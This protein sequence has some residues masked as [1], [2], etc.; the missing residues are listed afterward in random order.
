[1]KRIIKSFGIDIFVIEDYSILHIMNIET[2][3][4]I[5]C[6]T[7]EE[8][9]YILCH[10]Y[11]NC[12]NLNKHITDIVTNK[13]VGTCSNYGKYLDILKIDILDHPIISNSDFSGNIVLRVKIHV[14][15]EMYLDETIYC[16]IT[17]IDM[18]M[19]VYI[20]SNPPFTII[21]P[22]GSLTSKK[23]KKNDLLAVKKLSTNNT[24]S[25]IIII[26]EIIVK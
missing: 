16:K 26:A 6:H 19:G 11:F 23:F 21:I 5:Y 18:N 13:Y 10:E 12:K 20:S 3:P 4:K 17:K 8:N 22:F 24:I 14:S 7:F 1:M 15:M 2:Q 25:Q 9:L